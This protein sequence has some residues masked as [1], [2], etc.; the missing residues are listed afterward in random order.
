M[1]FHIITRC[2]RTKNILK[3]KDSIYK[4]KDIP[5][6]WWITFDTTSLKDIDADILTNLQDNNIKL[7]FKKSNP[8]DY[9]Q[10]HNQTI[11]IIDSGW[12]LFLDDDNILHEDFFD[13]II[14]SINE[15]P[16]KGV[17]VF[18]QFVNGKDFSGLDIRLA[19]PENMEVG[20]IDLAQYIIKRD[21][22]GEERFLENEY[23]MD[24]IFISKMYKEHPDQF[25]FIDKVLSYYNYLTNPSDITSLP[26]VLVLGEEIS[27]LKSIK[28]NNEDTR[29]N[30]KCI[31]DSDIIKYLNE[32]NPDSIISI[33]DDYQKFTNLLSQPLDVRKR[34]LHDKSIS[35]NLGDH[36]YRCAMNYILNPNDVNTPLVSFFTPIYNTGKKLIRTYQS[37]KSQTYQNWEW[38]IVND[39]TD[40]GR[41]LKI[42]EQLA[43]EDPRIQIYDFRKKSGG[44]IGE[45]KWR[46]A[47]LCKGKWIMELDHDD[48]LTEDAAEL[49]VKAFKNYKDCKFVFSDCVEIDEYNNSLTYSDGWAFGY[50][51]Y[52]TENWNGREYKVAQ[53]PNINPI[54]IRHIVG[55]PNHFRAWEKDF[56]FEIGGHN[57]R[58]TIADDYELV[59]RS[60]LKTRFV[61]IRKM[62]Y[63][64][65]F[66]NSGGLSNTQNSSRG[67]IQRRVRTIAEFYNSKIHDRFEELGLEDWAYNQN[68]LNP[69]ISTPKFGKEESVTNYIWNPSNDYVYIPKQSGQTFLNL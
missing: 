18:N 45:S 21:L 46:A 20:K 42:A 1:M 17:I 44:I 8:G 63:L 60:F 28:V 66:Y 25:L 43:S 10:S 56:Y 58:L 12:C 55:I 48:I 65:Y 31:N 40:E 33:G 15:N 36:V 13:I 26:R 3:V 53:S 34:W 2:S 11:D 32:F 41:T 54:T 6:T 24:G 35:E 16:D 49:M 67:D 50:G 69:I 51:K 37:L 57:R 52:R 61:G 9:A 39:S 22:I 59:V 68:P 30:I 47:S 14:K 7:F 5:I 29:L 64:Q 23:K 4:N 19:K 27:E 38:V 62:L